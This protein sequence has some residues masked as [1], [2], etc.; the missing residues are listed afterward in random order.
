MKEHR[1]K[2]SRQAYLRALRWLRD[3]HPA[4]F[5]DLLAEERAALGLPARHERRPR[6]LDRSDGIA[7]T[8][9]DA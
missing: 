7:M 2:A 1:E 5:A 8:D 6:P 3:R 4:E 9:V